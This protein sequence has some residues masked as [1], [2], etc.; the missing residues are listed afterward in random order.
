MEKR[1]SQMVTIQENNEKCV[2]LKVKK[3]QFNNIIGLGC[4]TG[5]ETMFRLTKGSDHVC[6]VWHG[7]NNN[8]YSWEW[9]S[10]GCTLVSE[11]MKARGQIIQSCIA[12]DFGIYIGSDINK[13]RQTLYKR[14]P[15]EKKTEKFVAMWWDGQ[16]GRTVHRNGEF[17]K[18][19]SS[20]NDFIEYIQEIG[21]KVESKSDLYHSPQTNCCMMDFMVKI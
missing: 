13:I 3:N 19:F 11:N 12:D 4:F 16:N 2:I 21:G 14:K 18:G 17:W 15:T 1:L 9:G 7:E 8:N 5:N 6:T 20:E 10:S